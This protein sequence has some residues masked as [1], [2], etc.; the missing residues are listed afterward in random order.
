M[1]ITRIKETVVPYKISIEQY[2]ENVCSTDKILNNK[3]SKSTSTPAFLVKYC[4]KPKYSPPDTKVHENARQQ[5]FEPLLDDTNSDQ[6]FTGI[7]S[8]GSTPTTK[9]LNWYPPNEERVFSDEELDTLMEAKIKELEDVLAGKSPAGVYACDIQQSCFKPDLPQQSW[10]LNGLNTAFS[11]YCEENP[12]LLLSKVAGLDN[13]TYLSERKTISPL[14]I[15]DG[16]LWSINYNWRGAPKLWIIFDFTFLMKYVNAV[17][18]DMGGKC[19][20]HHFL[21]FKIS[22]LMFPRERP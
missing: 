5:V 22:Y 21:F 14:H 13:L 8:Y 2:L 10:S 20:Q 15:E 9:N 7:S 17:R 6:Q 19:V 18:K 16:D 4:C 12:D 1:T 11:R 3:C